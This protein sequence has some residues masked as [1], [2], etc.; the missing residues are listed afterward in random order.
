MRDK[1]KTPFQK[2]LI[3]GAAALTGYA[4]AAALVRPW[5]ERWGAT[6][7]EVA[8]PL[9]GDELME[10]A[11]ANHA[12]TIDAPPE[13][14]WPWLVQIGQDR[15]GFYSYTWLENSVLAHIHNAETVH[16]E[17]QQLRE[18]DFI[19]LASKRVYGDLPLLRVHSVEQNRSLVLEG[20]GAFVLQPLEGG[21][22]RVIIRSHGRRRPPLTRA[23]DFLF[24]GPAH[25]IMERKMLLGLKGRAEKAVATSAAA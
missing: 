14:V 4:I 23:I 15:G 22:T 2:T 16:P 13:T 21:K 17:W 1:K 24:F 8:A 9:P 18:G 11:S 7:K 10:Y 5:H 12:I 6:D 20:W 25:F 19:R 3:G